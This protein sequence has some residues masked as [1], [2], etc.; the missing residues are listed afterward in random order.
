M[1]SSVQRPLPPA[2]REH[3]QVLPHREARKDAA[4]L[5]HEAEAEPRDGVGRQRGDVA[6]AVADAAGPRLQ[7]AHDGEDGR[8]LAGAVAAE[9]ADDLAL[10]HGQRD[11]VQDVAVAVVGVD[12]LELEHQCAVPR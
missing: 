11:A 9:Q 12:V 8:G 3:G 10:P 5:R 7:I 4:L 1:R 2:A 6:V